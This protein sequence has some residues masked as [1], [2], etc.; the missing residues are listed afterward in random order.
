[1]S[2]QDLRNFHRS[3]LQRVSHGVLSK[4]GRH[5]VYGLLKHIKKKARVRC[6]SKFFTNY[7]SLL[8]SCFITKSAKR[9]EILG[10]KQ[11]QKQ[12]R[13][14][15]GEGYFL[16]LLFLSSY[17]PLPWALLVTHSKL[18]LFLKSKMAYNSSTTQPTH[19]NMPVEFVKIANYEKKHFGN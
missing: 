4:P 3:L 11:G 1:M 5:T 8:S 16:P 6:C 13:G 2:I 17:L 15:G 18:P 7:C 14:R 19:N 10:A 9:L 12:L